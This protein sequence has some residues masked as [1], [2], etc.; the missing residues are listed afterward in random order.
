MGA[1]TPPL[2]P[3]TSSSSVIT[4]A[5]A[6][7]AARIAA[8]SAV[9]P[10]AGRPYGGAG[11]P[12]PAAP[13]EWDD[14]E[15]VLVLP[16]A[17]PLPLPPRRGGKHAGRR[18]GGARVSGSRDRLPL[19]PRR[20]VAVVARGSKAERAAGEPVVTL[21]RA[22]V[23]AKWR[24]RGGMPPDGHRPQQWGGCRCAA[25][26][27]TGAHP[28]VWHGGVAASSGDDPPTRGGC[29]RG[30]RRFVSLNSRYTAAG[31]PPPTPASGP[32]CTAH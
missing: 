17:L 14:H 29:G 7:A 15:A 6:A 30:R 10:T 4:H 11:A 23:D 32:P 26:L 8:A 2:P 20:I 31:A 19:R 18:D 27:A 22:R 16:T 1:T 25:D 5:G 28:T 13:D 24:R 3:P 21:A 12:P 9:A